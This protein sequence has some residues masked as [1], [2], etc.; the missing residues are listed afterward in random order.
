MTKK[1]V[2]FTNYRTASTSFTLL[3]SEEYGLP[4]SAE[5]FSHER[6]EGL[7][8]IPSRVELQQEYKIHQYELLD[9]IQSTENLISELRKE[10]TETCFKIMP[11]QV[12]SLR[13]N[14]DI[15]NACDK[16]YFLYSRDFIRTVKSWIAVRLHGGFGN[17]GFKWTSRNYTVEKIKEIHLG[18]LGKKDTHIVDVDPTCN[19]LNGGRG[20]V[21]IPNMRL[22]IIDNYKR[23]AEVYREVGGELICKEDYFSGDRHNP[24]NKKINWLSDPNIEDFDV[25]SLF[26]IDKYSEV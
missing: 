20:I 16:V 5:L 19:A 4:Y 3:K 2:I 21:T 1:V 9:L 8:R 14:I 6:M 22:Q 26:T 12:E 17:T 24:Y 11:N 10:D 25:E 23:M 18:R 7:G 13:N 15:A